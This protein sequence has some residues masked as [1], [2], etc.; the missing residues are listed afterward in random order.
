M[1][2]FDRVMLAISAR[3]ALS[4]TMEGELRVI[5]EA[6]TLFVTPVNF[7]T[8]DIEGIVITPFDVNVGVVI[9]CA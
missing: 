8:I 4:S 1:S 6:S 7:E 2:W 5:S 3:S 9:D